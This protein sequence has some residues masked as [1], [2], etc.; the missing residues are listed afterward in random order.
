M[1]TS[2]MNS[3]WKVESGEWRVESV[4]HVTVT[5]TTT[6]TVMACLGRRWGGKIS[7]V[8][9]EF[10]SISWGGCSPFTY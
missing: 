1:N 7:V 3:G 2:N 8:C 4:G 10:L 6:P 5:M 9:F